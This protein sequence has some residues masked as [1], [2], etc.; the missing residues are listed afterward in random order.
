MNFIKNIKIMVPL[1]KR[2]QL[3]LL[4]LVFQNQRRKSLLP[5]LKILLTRRNVLFNI[6]ARLIDQY[7]V[8]TY[9]ETMLRNAPRKRSCRRFVRNQ[10]W[11]DKVVNN[12][13][14]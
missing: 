9:T 3:K 2:S 11:W 7:I 6:L 4:I 1:E 8:F 14:D 10:G 13:S 12:Y 5:I